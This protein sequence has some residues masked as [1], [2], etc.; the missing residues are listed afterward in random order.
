M[1]QF[2]RTFWFSLSASLLVIIVCLVRLGAEALAPLVTLMVIEVTFSFDNA[3]VNAKVLKKM[4]PL[5]QKLFLSVGILVAIFGMRLV[6]PI[7]IVALTAHLPWREVL[8]LALNN[9]LAYAHNLEIA[10]PTITAFGGSFLMML[11]LHFFMAENKGIHWIDTI[12]RPLQQLNKW[13]MPGLIT[14]AMVGIVAVAPFNHHP[15]DTIMSGGLG[16]LTYILIHGLTIYIGKRTETTSKLAHYTGWAAFVMFMYL[17][18]LDA[19]FSLDGVLGAFAITD[20]VILITA[21]LGIGAVWVR[22]MTVSMVRNGTLDAYRFLEHGA[23]YAIFVLASVMLFAAWYE[24][25]EALTGIMGVGLII[26]S[27]F[28]S[29]R[30]K[31]QKA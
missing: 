7:A 4:S 10:H 20:D 29:N 26:A 6:F 22:S 11:A 3:V 2:L 8:D 28:S 12:E 19:S 24:V 1:I 13:W 30:F 14:A 17:E 21:G 9:P 31:S 23:H 18:L 27:V 5:W 25:P 16:L 15:V